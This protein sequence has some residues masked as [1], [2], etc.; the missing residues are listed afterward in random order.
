M[1]VDPTS[2]MRQSETIEALLSTFGLE[3]GVEGLGFSSGVAFKLGGACCFL[4]FLPVETDRSRGLVVV[5][6]V[7][8]FWSH[9]AIETC[10]VA[11]HAK[12]HYPDMS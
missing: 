2:F 3:S 8:E 10:F 7:Q 4:Q 11:C 6:M 5:V 12:I 1:A 9:Q